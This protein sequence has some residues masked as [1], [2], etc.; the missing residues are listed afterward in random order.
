MSRLR[1]LLVVAGQAFL[2]SARHRVLHALLAAMLLLSVCAHVLAW[3]SGDDPVRQTKVV[4]DLSLSALALLGSLAAIFLGTNLVYQEV[5]RRTVYAVL[6]RPIGRGS[7][8]AG[9]LLGL[10]AVVSLACLAMGAVCLASIALTAGQAAWGKLALALLGT[11]LELA[12]VSGIGLL[13][14]VAAQPIEGAVF[15]VVLTAA[16]HMTA[17]LKLLGAQLLAD[18]GASPGLVLRGAAGALELLYVLLPNLEQFNLRAQAVHDLTIA[19]ERLLLMPLY[20]AVWLGILLA[21]SVLVFRR[22]VL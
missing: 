3:V 18:A 1:P 5:E 4:A 2:E 7:F 19:P 17:S 20:A 6:A 14:S 11:C 9:K 10:V 22:R 8:L 16:G 13:F 12:V 21:L 15:A